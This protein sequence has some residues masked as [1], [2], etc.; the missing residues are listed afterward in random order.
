M[1][2]EEE[3]FDIMAKHSEL[4]PKEV[5]KIIIDRRAYDYS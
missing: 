4:I 3:I 2:L 1:K 5:Q